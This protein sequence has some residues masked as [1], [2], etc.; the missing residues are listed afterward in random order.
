MELNEPVSP[1]HIR[2]L[3]ATVSDA[4]LQQRLR[5]GVCTWGD[6][7]PVLN[8]H[9][10]TYTRMELGLGTLWLFNSVAEG[11]K[12]IEGRKA[13]GSWE[14]AAVGDLVR[15]RYDGAPLDP[16]PE[17][18]WKRIREIRRYLS[19]EQYLDECL[20]QALPGHSRAEAE[21][22]YRELWLGHSGGVLALGF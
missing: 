5:E 19:L 21:R 4:G 13:G 18:F 15:V 3:L 22:V 2:A 8:L 11:K 1:E 20:E 6:V 7:L 14:R 17:P 10:E 12:T 16:S 9:P